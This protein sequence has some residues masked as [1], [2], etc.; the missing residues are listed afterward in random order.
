MAAAAMPVDENVPAPAPEDAALA[1]DSIARVVAAFEAAFA[2]LE[3]TGAASSIVEQRIDPMAAAR[4]LGATH[5]LL[6]V[7]QHL[8]ATADGTMDAAYA[9]VWERAYTVYVRNAS[10]CRRLVWNMHWTEHGFHTNLVYPLFML[11]TRSLVC[12]IACAERAQREALSF[13]TAIDIAVC[14]ERQLAAA[15]GPILSYASADVVSAVQAL[16]MAWP[17]LSYSEELRR[18]VELLMTRCGMLLTYADDEAVHCIEAYRESVEAAPREAPD[19][20]ALF[21]ANQLFVR[22]MAATFYD[23]MQ[24]IYVVARLFDEFDPADAAHVA[25]ADDAAL[26]A[27]GPPERYVRAVARWVQ[28]AADEYGLVERST[29]VKCGFAEWALRPGEHEVFRI[30]NDNRSTAAQNIL[31]HYR[32]RTVAD[33]LARST[34]ALNRLVAEEVEEFVRDRGAAADRATFDAFSGGERTG[35]ESVLLQLAVVEMIEALFYTVGGR[36]NLADYMM[37]DNATVMAR[38]A[39]VGTTREPMMMRL[40]HHYQLVWGRLVVRHDSV[41]ATFAHWL[42][43]MHAHFADYSP[44]AH[45]S[46]AVVH[47]AVLGVEEA[48]APVR[49]RRR[50]GADELVD[51]LLAMPLPP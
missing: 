3:L 45:R 23:M 2:Q 6:R 37:M 42:Y 12:R 34:A 20:V 38:Y 18:Y 19:A 17:A 26:L 29:R 9:P 30:E 32:G 49:R 16:A 47:D 4:L 13:V 44:T 35:A 48:P 40:F 46:I 22:F 25:R 31:R 1:P 11:A 24:D 33:A 27:S 8:L 10:A 5:A 36:L 41:V 21:R 15:S 28:T 39:E 7:Q 51:A 43:I 14:S 50:A